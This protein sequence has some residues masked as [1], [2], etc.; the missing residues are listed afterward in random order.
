MRPVP[1]VTL[2]LYRNPCHGT[3]RAARQ[4]RWHS[5]STVTVTATATATTMATV[6]V[7]VTVTGAVTVTVA[8]V[9]ARHS[10]V[11][12]LPSPPLPPPKPHALSSWPF[13]CILGRTNWKE[14]LWNSLWESV[15]QEWLATCSAMP[16]LHLSVRMWKGRWAQGSE[17]L[18][19]GSPCHVAQHVAAD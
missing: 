11:G 19:R 10:I 17:A 7:P 15:H 18:P 5:G 2:V 14:N 4:G 3:V 6:T 1:A 16:T 12:F 8:V 13:L 9:V